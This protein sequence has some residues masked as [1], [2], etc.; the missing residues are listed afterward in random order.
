MNTF[1]LVGRIGHD[2]EV[3][4]AGQVSVAVFSAA[5]DVGFGERK[6]TDWYRCQLW[7]KRAE[8]GLIPYL[9][10][11]AQVV[12][13]GELKQNKYQS[14]GIEKMSLDVNVNEVTLVGGQ[15]APAQQQASGTGGQ[16]YNQQDNGFAQNQPAQQQAP[17]Q[18][19]KFE[20]D[21]PFS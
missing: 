9:V 12:V 7:G 17:A 3:R 10:K 1:T 19:Q 13:S 21:I 18:Q 2:A 11:G 8:G 20:D 15:Q 5:V 4:M 16:Q 6:Q 14:D